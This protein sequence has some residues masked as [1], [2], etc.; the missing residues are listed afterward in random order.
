MDGIMLIVRTLLTNKKLLLLLLFQQFF[1][2]VAHL[3]AIFS[4]QMFTDNIITGK[5]P[6]WYYPFILINVG[7]LVVLFFVTV[8]TAVAKFAMREEFDLKMRIGL[9]WH[10]ICMPMSAYNKY[11][12]GDLIYRQKS[13]DAAARQILMHLVP[14]LVLATE[15]VAFVII[16]LYYEAFFAMISLT[17]IVL[18]FISIMWG[19]KLQ[20]ELSRQQEVA[21]GNL[22]GATMAV[23]NNFETIKSAGAE[24]NIFA[25]WS[26]AFSHS[27]AV[28]TEISTQQTWLNGISS[29][30]QVLCNTMIL[31][32]GVWFIM[33]GRITPGILLA[34][35]GLLAQILEPVG[36]IVSVTQSAVL[37]ATTLARRN[38]IMD[39]PESPYV[40]KILDED[41]MPA[42]AKLMG[43]I[44]L[45]DVTF[46]YDR[47]QPPLLSHFS[48]HVKAGESVAFVGFSGCGKST[49]ASL[50]SGLYEPWEGEILF[51]GVPRR[52]VNPVVFNNSVAVINQNIVLFEDTVANN[53][54]MWDSSIEDFAII[55][56]ARDAQIHQV[57]AERSNGYQTKVAQGGYNFSGGQRQ[58]IEIATAL[59]KEPTI[60]I[61][62][63]A[64]SALDSATEAK[65]MDAVN[66][67]GITQVIIAHRL[68]TIRDCSQILVMEHGKVLQRG[69]HDELLKDKDGLYAKLIQNA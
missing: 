9:F 13:N 47:N 57:I 59:A 48:L 45:R 14:S 29:L 38:E 7:F 15:I 40:A 67:L 68:S 55:L 63:E 43:E 11:S 18:T 2:L 19:G 17:S 66:A 42:S 62:D 32:I 35:Q 37:A 5:N 26:N 46:G 22:Q 64:T 61:M 24:E 56:A 34:C 51:D 8:P 36:E 25:K 6:E 12:A 53:I 52:S 30:L 58:R 54:R 27:M 21:K 23:F 16:M 69:T 4:Q 41:D 49:I 28:R 1:L 10:S 44:E 33:E 31:I 60:L 50:I 65:V 20:K 3:I 39:E